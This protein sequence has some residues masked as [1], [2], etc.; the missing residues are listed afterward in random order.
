MV[1]AKG[2]GNSR[3]QKVKGNKGRRGL[4]PIHKSRTNISQFADGCL[5]PGFEDKGD[6]APK[7]R[8]E[9]AW[10]AGKV[11]RGGKRGGGKRYS[12]A[13]K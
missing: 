1:T 11:E 6:K 12:S 9:S 2:G 7:K 5:Q 3:I 13:S 4:I 8:K 10:N